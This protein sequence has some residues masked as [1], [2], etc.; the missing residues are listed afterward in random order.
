MSAMLPEA[1]N[2]IKEFNLPKKKADKVLSSAEEDIQELTTDIKWEDQITV[3]ENGDGD[4]NSNKFDNM[5]GWV[6]TTS[7]LM[8]V[9]HEELQTNIQPIRLLL[10]KLRKLAYKMIYSMT[11]ILSEWKITLAKLKLSERIMLRNV[12]MWWNS[13]FDMLQFAIKY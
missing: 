1:G 10:I 5:E 2:L 4:P 8:D 6:D 7:E 9:K 3:A 11:L 12:S 13:T